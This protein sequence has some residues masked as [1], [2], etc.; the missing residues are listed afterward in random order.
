MQIL[1]YTYKFRFHK[2]SIVTAHVVCV[3]GEPLNVRPTRFNIQL[4]IVSF[5]I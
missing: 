2:S 5:N 4:Q 1:I 3:I